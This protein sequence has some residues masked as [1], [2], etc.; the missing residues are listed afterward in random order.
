[1]LKQRI[2]AWV[3]RD[4]G[5]TEF[6]NWDAVI[7]FASRLSIRNTIIACFMVSGIL[8]I[9]HAFDVLLNPLLRDLA[10]GCGIAMIVSFVLTMLCSLYMGY[11]VIHLARTR[12]EFR[13]L[14]RTDMLSG[15]LNRR[16]FIEDLSQVERGH[17]LILDIDRFKQINDRY[18]HL[19]GDDVIV[20]VA[21]TLC[22]I[23][24]PNHLVAR[25]GG[26]EFA[27]LFRDAEFADVIAMA[28]KLRRTI[29]N[30]LVESAHQSIAV[31]I[32]G[33]LADITPLRDFTAVYAAADQ[34]LYLAKSSGRNRIVLERDM[35]RTPHQPEPVRLD[36]AETA[37]TAA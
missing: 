1:M 5:L 18:G 32:S 14:S 12:L 23:T 11:A 35:P 31:T 9:L 25:I 2:E 6:D 8:L 16:A 4:I 27:I 26:E 29:A 33:G 3:I 19:A 17:L 30:R 20:S 34:A 10:I 15:L 21:R 7:R 28:E 22:D 36:L 24:G 37:I 13:Q